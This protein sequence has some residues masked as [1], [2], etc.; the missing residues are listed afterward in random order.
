MTTPSFEKGNEKID[1]ENN[2]ES[3]TSNVLPSEQSASHY[4]SEQLLRFDSIND[5]PVHNFQES[6]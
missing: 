6:L 1:S 5:Q 2:L 4:D 3:S